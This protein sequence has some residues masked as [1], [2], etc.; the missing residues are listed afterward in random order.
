M[1][2]KFGKYVLS[3]TR[4]SG[5]PRLLSQWEAAVLPG[6]LLKGYEKVGF[7]V[8]GLPLYKVEV[9]WC[10]VIGRASLVSVIGGESL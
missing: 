3:G 1:K 2:K 4:G 8:G 9:V 5:G 6:P 10:Y 7:G